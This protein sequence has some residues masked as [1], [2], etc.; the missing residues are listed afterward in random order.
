MSKLRVSV[1][2][3]RF[4][5]GRVEISFDC[6]PGFPTTSEPDAKVGK[7]RTLAEMIDVLLSERLQENR[8]PTDRPYK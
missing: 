3:R 1:W 6:Q 2:C 7:V 5:E 8:I 4:T